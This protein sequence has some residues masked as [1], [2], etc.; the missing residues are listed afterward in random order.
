[1]RLSFLFSVF[2]ALCPGG[3]FATGTRVAAQVPV[4]VPVHVTANVPLV[5]AVEGPAQVVLAP[6][7]VA[8][9]RV[10]VL[11]NIP[12]TLRIHSLNACA[13][14]L[15]PLNGSPGGATANSRDVEISCSPQAA[16]RQTIALI[17][18][19]MPR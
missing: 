13:L 9:I 16:G 6:G 12:W 11:A 2:I 15:A 18:T 1:M 17:Y 5:A 4:H 8:R 19:L 7:E 14:E 10:C 3:L